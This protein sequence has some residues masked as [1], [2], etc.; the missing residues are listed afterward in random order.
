[1]CTPPIFQ[2]FFLLNTFKNTDFPLKVHPKFKVLV[3]NYLFQNYSVL[4][5][6]IS[7]VISSMIIDYLAMYFLIFKYMGIVWLSFHYSLL[8]LTALVGQK[9]S[10][11]GGQQLGPGFSHSMSYRGVLCLSENFIPIRRSISESK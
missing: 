4:G 10:A 3:L 11:Q 8:V 1:M 6:S 7:T 5:F 2:S 9:H